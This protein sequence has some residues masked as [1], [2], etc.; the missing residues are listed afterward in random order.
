LASTKNVRIALVTLGAAWHRYDPP[1]PTAV[2]F[3]QKLLALRHAG[4]DAFAEHVEFLIT[5][6]R[7]AG[8]ASGLEL[9]MPTV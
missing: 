4:A 2:E 9:L 5:Q 7:V 1:W 6:S 3:R 8:S